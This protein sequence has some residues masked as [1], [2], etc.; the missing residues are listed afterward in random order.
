MLS[1]RLV[2][3]PSRRNSRRNAKRGPRGII[4]RSV[5]FIG[6]GTIVTKQ[7]ESASR[8]FFHFVR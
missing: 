5:Y 2:F 3:F 1:A 4:P 8:K 7:K 6:I